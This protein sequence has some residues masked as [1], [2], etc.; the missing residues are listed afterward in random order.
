[1]DVGAVP[2]K[3]VRFDGQAPRDGNT[4]WEG[5]Y[6]IRLSDAINL[7]PAL[8]YQNRPAGQNTPRGE[9]FNALGGLLRM[10]LQF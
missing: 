7:T 10:T 3:A 6:D 1:M 2:F 4:T 9:T 8:F 5:W